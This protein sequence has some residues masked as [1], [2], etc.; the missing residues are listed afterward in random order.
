MVRI[1]LLVGCV[2]ISQSLFAQPNAGE[3]LDL[4]GQQF[5]KISNESLTYTSAAN[6]GKSARK[7]E[8]KR[9]ELIQQVKESEG[10]VR[11]MGP[12][13]GSTAF[14]DSIVNY[15][16]LTGIVLNRDYGKIVDLEEVSEQ[17]YDAMEAYMLAKE[18]AEDRL[19]LAYDAAVTQYKAFAASNNIKLLESNDALSKKIEKANKVGFYTN[20][21]YL[22]FFKSYKNEAYLMDAMSR[23]DINAIE[24]SRNAL[25][26]SSAED[27]TKSGEV[28]A[29]SGDPSLKTALQQV[30][31][32]YKFESGEKMQSYIQFLI[33]KDNFE[34]V[35]KAFDATPASKRTKETVDTYNKTVNDFNKKVSAAN[36][37]NDELNKKRSIAFKAWTSAYE[38]FLARH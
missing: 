23:N 3:Y 2:L 25:A 17:S 18:K 6:H 19:D 22:L 20:K 1:L 32:F 10:I 35:K 24:Q 8:K 37:V 9:N 16:K 29:F 21:V 34:K 14:R 36:A 30:L 12:F 33:A 15:F 11:K 28:G 7:V 27:L 38:D 26:A 13:E 5:Q 31:N 4:V